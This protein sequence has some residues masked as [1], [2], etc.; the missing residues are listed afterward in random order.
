MAAGDQRHREPGGAGDE[1]RELGA[2]D[3]RE[4]AGEQAAERRE[5]GEGPE[6]EADD[7]PAE[8]VGRAELED[9]VR[10]RRPEREAGAGDEEEDRA[11]PDRSRAARL[12]AA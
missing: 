5:P 4:P 3:V 1:E 7:P 11:G 9:R 2:A 12:R 10:V 8:V 6:E